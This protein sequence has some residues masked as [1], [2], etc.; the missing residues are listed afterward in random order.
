MA[1]APT[2]P[3][4]APDSSNARGVAVA[5][6]RT[7]R[8][9]GHEAYLAGGCV[10]DELLGIEPSDYDVATDA[11][12]DRI[13]SL[14]HRTAAVGQSFGVILVKDRGEVVEVATFRA[15]GTYTDSR[16]PDSVRFSTAADD[17]ARRDYTVN[18]LFLDPLATPEHGDAANPTPIHGGRVI[19]L[20][21]GVTDLRARV[22][23]AVGDPDRRLAEDHL[24]ALR[25][26]RLS[27]KLGF[28]I[29]TATAEAITRHA[30]DLRGVSRER[31]GDELRMMIAHPSRATAVQHLA[32]LALDAPVFNEPPSTAPMRRLHALSASHRELPFALALAAVAL[33]R[34]PG[35]SDAAADERAIGAV[36]SRWR[37]AL[38]LSNDERDRLRAVLW[39]R[40]VLQSGWD[41]LGVAGRKRL[42]AR[43]EFEESLALVSVDD[44]SRAENV[45]E[46][47]ARLAE[48]HGG[49]APTPFLSGDD[50]LAAGWP[51]GPRFKFVLDQVYDAQLEGR[52]KD[53][54]EARELAEKLGV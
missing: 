41:T 52:V 17:A 13:R 7:L 45:R 1:S 26:V 29:E 34:V 48:Q 50:L 24:R 15:D 3:T 40:G 11:T 30:S 46:T 39:A 33:D 14:F 47:V 4:H 32:E 28:T 20:V 10:R 43:P 36:V 35:L 22:L 6:V 12:P 49:L 9:A 19:D 31:I 44:I 54:A 38:T 21:G 23:R 25:A 42:A 53:F 2:T 51:P 16:R 18:A 37:T 8:H 5:I 27:A